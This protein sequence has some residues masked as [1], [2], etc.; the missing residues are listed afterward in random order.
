MIDKKTRSGFIALMTTLVVMIIVIVFLASSQNVS[1]QGLSSTLSRRL[2]TE[3]Q[4]IAQSCF[5]DTLI[6]LKS[7]SSYSGDSLNIADGFCTITVTG[8]GS[9]KTIAITA[10]TLNDYFVLIDAEVNLI[11]SGETSQVQVVSFEIN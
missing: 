8:A 1:T 9:T 6:L 10:N 11:E 2:S 5:E 3:A 7:D 4:Y